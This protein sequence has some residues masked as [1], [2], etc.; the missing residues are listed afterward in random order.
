[1]TNKDLLDY[2]WGW[3]EYHAGQRLVAFR[4][5][6]VFLGILVVGFSK[7]IE[8]DN[9]LFARIVAAFG[10]FVSLAFL[11]LEVRNEQLVEVG[12]KALRHLEVSDETLEI[13]AKLRLL[14]ADQ[15]RSR[16]L[17]HKYWLRAIYVACTVLFLAG[18]VWAS[19]LNS[20]PKEG[21]VPY[22]SA[23]A[24]A[25]IDKD[26]APETAGELNYAITRLVD[27]YLTRKG[28][29]RYAHVNEVVGALECAKLEL[30]RRVAAP[31]EDQKLQ[32]AGDVYRSGR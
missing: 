6:L 10:A 14:H 5:F 18:A 30:Y 17:S 23:D 26:G 11:V 2:A 19:D 15:G 1:M 4:F 8:D 27:D 31:Y 16:W 28:E 24:R 12:R 25:R 32:D 7:G 22:V 20:E 3:F 13:A 21:E 9:L 29:L